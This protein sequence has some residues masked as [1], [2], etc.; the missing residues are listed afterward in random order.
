MLVQLSHITPTGKICTL[1]EAVVLR[2]RA[3]AMISAES[4]LLPYT[5]YVSIPRYT[6]IRSSLTVLS[7]QGNPTLRLNG[8]I[9]IDGEE[10]A[11]DHDQSRGYLS[12]S[13][14]VW[15]FW[16][17]LW[18]L[19][20]PLEWVN[21]SRMGSKSYYGAALRCPLCLGNLALAS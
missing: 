19:A 12:A 18:I 16:W 4:Y 5:G 6:E 10:I 20:L 11:V 2:Y 14:R 15:D 21:D 13:G 9:T 7:L 1:V 8:T 3:M 17:P